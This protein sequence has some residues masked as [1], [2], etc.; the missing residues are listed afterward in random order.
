MQIAHNNLFILFEINLSF[1][2]NKYSMGFSFHTYKLH[3]KAPY[4]RKNCWD[5]LKDTTLMA[6]VF[7]FPRFNPLTIIYN[8]HLKFNTTTTV[9]NYLIV[10]PF[11]KQKEWRFFQTRYS[12]V[13]TIP[14]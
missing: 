5:F 6:S 7:L 13:Q 4:T 12:Y 3:F 8:S 1:N 11:T 14:T 9:F 2:S 10:S